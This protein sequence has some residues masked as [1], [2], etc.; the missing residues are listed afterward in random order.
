MFGNTQA[1]QSD[2]AE[3]QGYEPIPLRAQKQPIL[4][5]RKMAKKRGSVQGE[6]LQFETL[7]QLAGDMGYESESVDFKQDFNLFLNTIIKALQQGNYPIL[8][9]AVDKMSG[10]PDNNPQNPQDQEHAC[11]ITGYLRNTDEVNITH[12]GKTYRVDVCSL[13]NAN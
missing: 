9:F 3:E 10:F 6:I 4:S 11:V 5:L 13:F 8:A 12:W 2:E 7:G 1:S